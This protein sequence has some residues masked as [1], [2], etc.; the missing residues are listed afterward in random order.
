M[1]S[2]LARERAPAPWHLSNKIKNEL[3]H[4]RHA[5]RRQ[6]DEKD[7]R[8]FAERGGKECRK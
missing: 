3:V 7:G 1:P 2:S 5:C 6:A 4:H 8:S